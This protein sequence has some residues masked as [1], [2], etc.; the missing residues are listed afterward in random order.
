MNGKEHV[1]N[2]CELAKDLLAQK[3]LELAAGKKARRPMPQAHRPEQDIS[4][5]LKPTEARECQQFIG[6]ARW[7]V[8][9][10]RV[11]ILHEVSPLSSQLALPRQGHFEALMNV[12]ACL[13]R[14]PES[15]LVFD[16]STPE[17][18][19]DSMPNTD[20]SKGVH[21]GPHEEP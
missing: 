1:K 12:F 19:A 17:V 11:D 2:A 9:L 8:E 13:D 18:P 6:I 7:A 10:G 3:G 14:H 5:E 4:P 21:G 16:P 15:A 20:W